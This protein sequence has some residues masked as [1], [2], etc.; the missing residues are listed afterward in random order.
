MTKIRRLSPCV[1]VC[2]TYPS[3]PFDPFFWGRLRRSKGFPGDDASFSRIT[4]RKA[5]PSLTHTQLLRAFS[6]SWPK[7]FTSRDAP[8]RDNAWLAKIL[9]DFVETKNGAA[10]KKKE[11]LL[12]DFT[13]TPPWRKFI[14]KLPTLAVKKKKNTESS[15]LKVRSEKMMK[16]PA[17]THFNHDRILSK[18]RKKKRSRKVRGMNIQ[19]FKLNLL[20]LC[21]GYTLMGS[22]DAPPKIWVKF[23]F[24]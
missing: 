3:N 21:L 8:P 12:L 5:F 1:C 13:W 17:C 10:A 9:Y 11:S 18:E 2:Q 15:Q 16:I 6:S 24:C 20:C 19:I 23:L 14:S 4:A 22:S 7:V